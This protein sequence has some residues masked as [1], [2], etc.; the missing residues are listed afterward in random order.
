VRYRIDTVIGQLVE[1]FHAKKIWARDACH[2]T[3][4]WMRK[5]LGHTFAVLFCCQL[6]LPPLHSATLVI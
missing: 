1:R 3:S 2:L 6:E 5:L 4:R